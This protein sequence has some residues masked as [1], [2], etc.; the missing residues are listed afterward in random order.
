MNTLIE[1]A[2]RTGQ[3]FAFFLQDGVSGTVE[4]T[5]GDWLKVAQTKR[6]SFSVRSSAA[7]QWSL[8]NACG[9]SVTEFLAQEALQTV[10]AATRVETFTG[11]FPFRW[12]AGESVYELAFRGS[13]KRR[14]YLMVTDSA[15]NYANNTAPTN[16]IVNVGAV[17]SWKGVGTFLWS[18]SPHSFSVTLRIR[19]WD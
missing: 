12:R 8:R 19:N 6:F 4:C 18:L 9:R 3:A 7:I 17:E 11:A 16:R 2:S 15:T 14:L 10:K 13:R 5:S 1:A